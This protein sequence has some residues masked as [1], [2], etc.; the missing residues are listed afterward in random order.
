LLAAARVAGVQRDAADRQAAAW[1]G[2][3]ARVSAA[4][5][6]QLDRQALL[7]AVPGG[8]VQ[9]LRHLLLAIGSADYA[10]AP[11]LI[12][13]ARDRIG[14]SP[15]GGFSLGGCLLD[16]QEERLCLFREAAACAGHLSIVPGQSLFWDG[17][18]RVTLAARGLPGAGRQVEAD[19]SVAALGERGLANRTVPPHLADIP[20]RARQALPG[21]WQG[22]R[23]IGWPRQIT[24]AGSDCGQPESRQQAAAGS[25]AGGQDAGRQDSCGQDTSGQDVAVADSHG[26]YDLDV[27]FLPSW[28]ATSCGFTVV[29]PAKHTM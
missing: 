9:I 29:I 21:L 15:R 19:L 27:A 13:A 3:H 6:V 7:A 1:L 20:L 25:E 14:A 28:P 22:G 18:Y 26:P 10:P 24:A 11:G 8:A 17:R 2:R 5:Y 16:W 4:G 23:L 12:D